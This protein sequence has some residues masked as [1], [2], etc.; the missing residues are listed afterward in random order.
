[1]DISAFLNPISD[2][3]PSGENMEYDMA[4]TDMELASQYGEETQIGDHITEAEEPDFGELASKAAAVLGQTHDIRAAV[5]LGEAV[6]HTKGVKAFGEVT[7]LLRGF[8]E[9]FWD[10]CHPQLDED[11]G[12]AT[13][14]INAVQ[15][16]A[17]GDRMLKSLRKTGLSNSRVFGK[18]TLRDIEV[19]EG[20]A[21]PAPGATPMDAGS[22]AAAFKDTDEEELAATSQAISAALADVRAMDEVFSDKTPGEG[23]DLDSLVSMLR[24]IER[25]LRP[26]VAG[27]GGDVAE[28]D[29]ADDMAPGGGGG[30]PMRPT[31]GG[32]GGGAI[33]SP[34]D[35]AA[36]LD[37]IMAY[38]AQYEPSSPLPVLLAR[39]KKLVNADF[40]TIIEDMAKDGLDEVRKIGGIVVEDDY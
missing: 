23:P 3:A 11:D 14:R 25:V 21:S 5:F 1:M 31:G 4:F 7:A 6:L 13:M 39:A 29:G 19:A 27:E 38:Y 32:G 36:A 15:A 9:D 30:A 33:T 10:S 37:R 17:D 12:D 16:L 34:D 40:L 35:V 18:V 24:Q 28:D 2:D 20:S 8:L 22:I 26:Y